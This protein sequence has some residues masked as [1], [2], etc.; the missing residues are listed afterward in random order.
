MR[1]RL[2][3][4]EGLDG[5]GK[6]TQIELLS[7][8]LQESGQPVVITRWNSSRLISKA[9][10]RAKK[11]QLLT[12]YLFSTLHAADFMYRMEN[13]IIPSLYEGYYVIADRYSYTALARDVARHVDRAWVEHLYAL[14]PKPD[15]AFYCN[16]PVEKSLDR[17]MER[18]EG[19]L[20]SFYE[21]GM[22]VIHHEDPQEAFRQFQSR[23][24]SEYDHIRKQY[25][26]IEID[27]TRQI[28][29]THS[30]ITSIVN[31]SIRIWSQD[32]ASSSFDATAVVPAAIAGRQAHTLRSVLEKHLAPHAYPGKLIVLE[33]A[34]KHVT[35]Y[36]A[37]L[38]YH[39]LLVKGVDVQ[40]GLV[41]GTWV[42]AEVE[43]KALKKSVLSLSTKVLLATSEIVLAYEQV[44]LPALQRGAIVIL[45]G[46][47]AN[48]A[49]RYC[50]AGI[51]VEWFEPMAKVFAIMPDR[52]I[53][54]DATL[55][56]LMRKRKSAVHPEKF[57]Q[58]VF[59]HPSEES[60]ESIDLAMLQRVVEFYRECALL[61]NW[62]KVALTN[63]P[64]ELHQKIV[65]VVAP[66]LCDVSSESSNAP[67]QEVLQFLSRFDESFL[68]A[69]R[70]S[71]FS[72]SLFDQTRQLHGYGDRERSLLE[73]AALLHDIGHALSDK[74]HDEFTYDAI[75]RQEF[76]SIGTLEKELIAN[77]AYL[78]RQAFNKM[79][80]SHLSRLQA[81]DQIVVKR[82]ASLLRLADA[83]DEGGKRAVHEVR[84][85]E[86]D[87]ILFIDLHAVSKAL[88]ERAAV[89]RKADMF[90]HIY[91]KSVVVTRNGV[92]KRARRAQKT[93]YKKDTPAL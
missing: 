41:G 52:T 90:E 32:K 13:I 61:P 47:L 48:L 29:Q 7:R 69:R 81:N 62:E 84:G 73:Y 8:C 2:I 11:A 67:L 44:I 22:D 93:S 6:T 5:A 34:D 63:S 53:F 70:V 56:E 46:Y 43:R 28:E 76:A 64:K 26:L 71:E 36:Q 4:F 3:I 24:A 37:N 79:T 78:H 80:F 15:L 82:L 19:E 39:A 91:K 83:L 59:S 87:N 65:E 18:R 33:G 58:A 45:D 92:E 60:G 85:Y 25:G 57:V 77:I 10:K 12:P 16:A 51:S 9:I 20:P 23:I 75:L 49:A 86:E 55:H 31:E 54:L 74:K 72:V 17:V 88:P 1:G 68:H 35:A 66:A 30:Y 21:S 38:L 40:L 89:L 42:N 27:T 14:A 50:A